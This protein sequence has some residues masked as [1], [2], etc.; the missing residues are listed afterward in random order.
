[1]RLF[2]AN[3][4]NNSVA[5]IDIEKRGDS[6]VIGFIPTGWYPSAL[7]AS[8]DGKK[9][10]IGTAKGMTFAPNGIDKRSIGEILAGH[11]SL[12]D[13][14]DEKQLSGYT[15]QVL[16][17]TPTGRGPA[18]FNVDEKRVF[19]NALGK[20]KYVLYIIKEN[21]TDDQV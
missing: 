19:E 15:R 6:R 11:V 20:I 1:D 4:D 12:V 13:A 18:Q 7:A 8:A 21:R 2:V 3:A 14:P 17:N 5:V 16:A 9:L 10:Y